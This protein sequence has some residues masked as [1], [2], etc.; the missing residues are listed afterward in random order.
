[1]ARGATAVLSRLVPLILNFRQ[2]QTGPD[3]CSATAT[4]NTY[5][6]FLYNTVQGGGGFVRRCSE[7]GNGLSIAYARSVEADQG[8]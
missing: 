3:R 1:M 6:A 7:I 2:F 8:Q 5:V 4:R